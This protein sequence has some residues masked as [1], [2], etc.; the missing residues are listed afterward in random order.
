MPARAG[1]AAGIHPQFYLVS[2]HQDAAGGWGWPLPLGE[3]LAWAWQ[4][5]DVEVM[6]RERKSGFGWGRQQAGSEQGAQDVTAWVFGTS[7]QV[8]LTGQQIW[9]LGAPLGRDRGCWGKPRRWSIGRL[10]L[11]IRAEL[12]QSAEVSPGWSRSPDAWAEMTG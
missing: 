2:A 3:L 5:W 12:W 4:R 10:L 9:G 1:I 11:E 7:A 8:I 6:S